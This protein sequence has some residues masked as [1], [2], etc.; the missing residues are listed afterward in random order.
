MFHIFIYYYIL[1]HSLEVDVFLTTRQTV[2]CLYYNTLHRL[3]LNLSQTSNSTPNSNGTCR[4]QTVCATGNDL[5]TT[6]TAP[7][8]HNST[9]DRILPAECTTVGG[10]L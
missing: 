4:A 10:M 7:N 1:S 9:L 2:S 5:P 8:A 3:L 6:L